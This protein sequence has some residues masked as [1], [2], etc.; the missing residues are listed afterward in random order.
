MYL[1][2]FLELVAVLL[3]V[4]VQRT[5]IPA[6]KIYEQVPALVILLVTLIGV[7]R[8]PLEG[9]WTGFWGA[10]L[11]GAM[12][13]HPLGHL[14]LG[15]MSC[16]FAAGL[17]GQQVFPDRIPVLMGLVFLAAIITRLIEMLLVPPGV[18]GPFMLQSLVQAAYASALALPLGL[19]ARALFTRPPGFGDRGPRAGLSSPWTLR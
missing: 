7:F 11:L 14:F 16:G 9:T 6:L 5:W 19:L 10:L 15:Y 18:Y 4:V 2:F 13:S 8:G 12:A 3:L 1:Y 17:L